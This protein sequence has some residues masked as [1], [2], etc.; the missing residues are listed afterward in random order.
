M[1]SLRTLVAKMEDL[2]KSLPKR[3]K[4]K[5]ARMKLQ[6]IAQDLNTEKSPGKDSAKESSKQLDDKEGKKNADPD[7][8]HPPELYN[9]RHR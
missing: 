9:Q 6:K 3:A 1:G 4:I 7:A 5:L 2:E 8:Q